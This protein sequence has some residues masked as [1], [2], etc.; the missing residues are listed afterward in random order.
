[1]NTQEKFA[2]LVNQFSYKYKRSTCPLSEITFFVGA[3]FSKSWDASY[4]TGNQLFDFKYN[5]FSDRISEIFYLLQ[6]DT[7]HIDINYIKTLNYYLEMQKIYPVLRTRYIDNQTINIAIDEI[8]AH[9]VNRFRKEYSINYI[10]SKK[11][12]NIYWNKPLNCEQNQIVDF[13]Y[14]LDKQ[15]TGDSN[16][17]EGLKYSFISTNY[18]FIVETIMSS[19][20][21]KHDDSDSYI[22]YLYRGITSRLY[23][24]QDNPSKILE[25]SMLK[26]L[27]KINGGF[28]IFKDVNNEYII[29]YRKKSLKELTKNPPVIMLPNIQQNYQS[30]YFTELFIKAIRLLYDTNV[31]VIVGSSFAEEDR[32]LRYLIR[33]FAEDPSDFARKYIFYIDLLSEDKQIEKIEKIFYNCPKSLKDIAFNYFSGTFSEFCKLTTPNFA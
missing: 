23:C 26:S 28:E 14:S 27:Y 20:L 4:P 9:I 1:M 22:N 7:D 24:G 31:L 16:F 17:P 19:V 6:P 15:A 30:E 13:F 25:H 32:L 12:P 21:Q 10:V 33:H 18:D 11:D 5:K 2:Q 8:K 3:G 29:D